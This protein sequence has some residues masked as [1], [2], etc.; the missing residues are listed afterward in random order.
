MNGKKEELNQAMPSGEA[1]LT[2]WLQI[3]RAEY[4]EMPGLHLS[5][6]EGQRL[7]GM[8]A[9]TCEALLDALVRTGYLR[10]T[11]AGRYVRADGG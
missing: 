11:R 3:V 7:W 9:T 4:L 8:D 6:P 10:R 1:T 2:K 5:V